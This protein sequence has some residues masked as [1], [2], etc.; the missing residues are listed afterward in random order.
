MEE[1]LLVST[2]EYLDFLVRFMKEEKEPQIVEIV[3]QNIKDHL[4]NQAPLF[5][6]SKHIYYYLIRS[7]QYIPELYLK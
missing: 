2:S 7:N 4:N 1:D 6:Y 5:D 3:T